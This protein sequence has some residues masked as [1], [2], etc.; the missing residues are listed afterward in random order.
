MDDNISGINYLI[1]FINLNCND[2][3]L[4]IQSLYFE[5]V[6]NIYLVSKLEQLMN[7]GMIYGFEINDKISNLIC[8]NVNF[9]TKYIIEMISKNKVIID[10]LNARISD[11]PSLIL[12]KLNNGQYKY[13][14]IIE[15][16]YYQDF[17]HFIKITESE[18]KHLI[19]HL[20]DIVKIHRYL[21]SATWQCWIKLGKL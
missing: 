11:H 3:S 12:K 8:Q 13:R 5:L 10:N 7:D 17:A 1:K 14:I 21:S 6:K 18:L 20:I 19:I 9:D 15:G 2:V 16:Y 4:Y